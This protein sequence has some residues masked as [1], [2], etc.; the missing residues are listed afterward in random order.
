MQGRFFVSVT[1]FPIIFQE[2]SKEN[3]LLIWYDN[4]KYIFKEMIT[5]EEGNQMPDINILV[6][7]DEKEIADLIEIYLVSDGYKVFKAENALKGLD[8]LEKEEIH[9]VLL[10]I[11]M[12][13]M[14][15]L[16]MCKKIR[17]TNNIPIIMLSAKSTDLDKI[18]GLGTGAD[19]YV[20]KPFN[21]L[22]LT[23]RVKSQLRRYTQLNPNSMAKEA[24][25]SEI[26]I[27]GMSINKDNHK[28]VVD[29]EE[30]KLTPI[31]FDI[32]YLLASNPGKVF[33]TDEIFERVWNEKVYEANNTVMVHIR[34]LRGK[35][36]EDTRQSKIIT[37]VW[38]VGYKIEK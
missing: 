18:L 25:S 10:D 34:R 37:T 24:V 29:G 11:M 4:H 38:G 3:H 21:P 36:K 23:A 7:D 16:E 26:T 6:V 15:G 31:E 27:K 9:L 30:I 32:L 22:E 1:Y 17:E 2:K 5:Y 19:D 33:S 35:M 13:G 20:V 14:N 12:P 8:I 28:V